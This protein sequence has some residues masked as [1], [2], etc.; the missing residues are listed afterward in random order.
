MQGE[1][2]KVESNGYSGVSK[3]EVI[4]K[5]GLWRAEAHAIVR[6]YMVTGDSADRRAFTVGA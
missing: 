1:R 4:S 6:D 5:W 2:Q 3:E